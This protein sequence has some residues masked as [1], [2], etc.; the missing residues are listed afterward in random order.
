[1]YFWSKCVL[2]LQC[3][4]QQRAPA[5]GVSNASFCEAIGS[6]DSKLSKA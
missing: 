5:C 2:H 6:I 3:S 1:M 4:D